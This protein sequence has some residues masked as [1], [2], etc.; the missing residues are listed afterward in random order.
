MQSGVNVPLNAQ[1]KLLNDILMRDQELYNVLRTI[2]KLNLPNS[3]VG[4]GSITQ[5]VWNQIFSKDLGF[6][7]S[8]LDIVYFDTDL[9]EAKENEIRNQLLSELPLKKYNI[10]V[11]NEARVHLWY[12]HRFGQKINPYVSTEDAI[13]TWPT[14]ASSLGVYLNKQQDIEAFAPYGL[15]DVFSGIVRPN[16]KM[17]TESIY[18]NKAIKWKSKWPELKVVAW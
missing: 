15:N 2:S 4:G 3:Y 14:T 5:S 12:Q 13:S 16:K 1:I 18:M 9:S 6:G 7:I 11:K 8:D 17:I 10:D